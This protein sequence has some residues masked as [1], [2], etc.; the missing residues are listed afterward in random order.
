M[1]CSVQYCLLHG[2][3]ALRWYGRPIYW[4]SILDRVLTTYSAMFLY[5]HTRFVRTRLCKYKAVRLVHKLIAHRLSRRTKRPTK[6]TRRLRMVFLN[7]L[8][9]RTL[10]FMRYSPKPRPTSSLVSRES[11]ITYGLV[12]SFFF[13]Y[14]LQSTRVGDGTSPVQRVIQCGRKGYHNTVRR[15]WRQNFSLSLYLCLSTVNSV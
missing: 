2:E 6:R 1:Y 13:I 7:I 11:Q 10:H 4:S 15:I 14:I 3:K 5:Y 8:E 12:A 9:T